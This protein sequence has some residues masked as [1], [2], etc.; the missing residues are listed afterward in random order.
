MCIFL[1][2]RYLFWTTWG[3]NPKIEKARLDG[4]RRQ[5]IV[6][7]GLRAHSGIAL[8]LTGNRLYWTD[9]YS[10]LF[11]STDFDGNQR[12]T[13]RALSQSQLSIADSLAFY[14]PNNR[15]YYSDLAVNKIK[16]FT[17]EGT[18]GSTV[19]VNSSM[20]GRIA[21]LEVDYLTRQPI[22]L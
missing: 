8:D 10:N 19:F 13:H 9:A 17:N 18:T 7:T 15:F 21:G 2:Y 14:Q 11:Q 20:N 12:I 16:S 22:G 3:N 6:S 5:V 1:I 4:Q